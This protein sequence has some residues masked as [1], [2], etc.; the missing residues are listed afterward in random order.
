MRTRTQL[1]ASA[2]AD[3]ACLHAVIRESA[4]PV[5][6]TAQ[7]HA[8]HN[9]HTHSPVCARP[10]QR[11]HH[12]TATPA[13][14]SAALPHSRQLRLQLSCMYS[15][16]AA[17]MRVCA[18]RWAGR[19]GGGGVGD[20]SGRSIGSCCITAQRPCRIARPANARM[21]VHTHSV[22]GVAHTHARMQPTHAR[23][24]LTH[25][26]A[27]LWLASHSPAAAQKPQCSDSSSHAAPAPKLQRCSS[28]AAQ[29]H[30][31]TA[32]AK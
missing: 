8:V 3:L 20:G 6:C 19:A 13:A 17:H 31:S 15:A 9:T 1:H 12:D 11:A 25:A 14:S 18:G 4:R 27:P 2:L 10:A 26:R 7:A 32:G 22:A 30:S 29:Q 23:M 5:A 24:H 21:H 16:A 28:A